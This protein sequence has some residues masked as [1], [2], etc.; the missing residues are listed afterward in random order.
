MHTEVLGISRCLSK[1][2]NVGVIARLVGSETE[3]IAMRQLTVLHL[4]SL[5]SSGVSETYEIPALHDCEGKLCPK[6]NF[7]AR[8]DVALRYVVTRKLLD[9]VANLTMGTKIPIPKISLSTQ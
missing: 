5:P 6:Q 2:C 3:I 1:A 7:R 4:L 9:Y 8:H